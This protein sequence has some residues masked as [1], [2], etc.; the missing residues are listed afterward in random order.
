MAMK[1]LRWRRPA[2]LSRVFEVVLIAATLLAVAWGGARLSHWDRHS[3]VTA[4][5]AA[6]EPVYDMSKGVPPLNPPE[7]RDPREPEPQAVEARTAAIRRD[8]AAI[9]A[10]CRKAAGDDWDK[11][12]KDTEPYRAALKARVGQLRALPQPADDEVESQYEALAGRDN[13]PLFEVGARFYLPYLFDPSV[14]EPFRRER[15]VVA[16]HRWLRQQGIDLIF[17]PAPRMT[18][19]YV[20]HFLDSCP[21]D[22]VIAPHLRRTLLEM[23]DEDVEVVDGFSLF[24]AVR[25]T[26]EEY[27]YNAGTPDWAPRAARAMAKEVADRIERYKFGARARYGLPLLKTSPGPFLWKGHIG[28]IGAP[29]YESLTAEQ[30][31]RATAAQTTIESHVMMLDGRAP[32]NNPDSPVVVIGNCWVDSFWDQLDKELNLLTSKF[33]GPAHTTE[34]LADFLRDPT[35]LR[36]CRVVVWITSEQQMTAFKPLPPLILKTLQTNK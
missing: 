13:F 24:R 17:V 23:L 19:V 7:L 3:P 16:V 18:E 9:E 12:Q 4:P 10:Q 36:L 6:A 11:W 8:A 14:I 33:A 15:P 25:D 30:S 20:E 27:L 35:R 2:I 21:P 5:A 22:A 31:A 26:D 29:S 28:G 32:P 34:E 1:S